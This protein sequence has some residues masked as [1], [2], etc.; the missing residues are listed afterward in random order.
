MKEGK[1]ARQENKDY[2]ILKIREKANT[3]TDTQLE[4]HTQQESTPKLQ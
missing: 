3:N 1:K 4:G 2:Y